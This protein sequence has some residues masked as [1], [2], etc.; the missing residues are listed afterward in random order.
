MKTEYI[1]LSDGNDEA[2]DRAGRI[3]REG[4][5]VAFPTETVYGLGGNAYDPT[6]AEKIF[7]AKGRPS[8]NPLIVHVA[9]PEEAE[10]FAVTNSTYY[11]LAECFMPGPLT[12][13]LPKREVIPKSVT[14]GLNTVAVRCPSHP[15]ARRLIEA[16][17]VPVAAPSAN[18][19]G[20]PSPTSG[21]HV[22]DDMNGKIPMILDGGESAIGVESTVIRLESDG[23]TILRPGEITARELLGVVENV[24]V[25]DAVTDPSAAGENPESPGMKYRHYAPRARLVLVGGSDSAFAEYVN[26]YEGKCA[27]LA[28][29]ENKNEYNC[30]CILDAGSKRSP[31]EQ[32]HNLFS[33]L[34]TCDEIDCD[35]IF[36]HLPPKTDE[37]LALYNRII[38]AAGNEIINLGE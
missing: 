31:E 5:L 37:Y 22:L 19:S 16:A 35:I 20:K 32:M 1:L 30:A 11:K 36:A 27:V 3:L 17:G 25:A 33:L 4:G 38:R 21:R 7:A 2:Y 29:T 34:R 13:I 26:S 15:A 23:C 8:D 6:A 18:I 10:A 28:Y 9:R 14:G 24:Y 12:V